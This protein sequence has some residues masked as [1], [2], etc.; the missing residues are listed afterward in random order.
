M[1]NEN[2]Q[3]QNSKSKYQMNAKAQ[4]PDAG[5]TFWISGFELLND[6]I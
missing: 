4:M 1:S 3:Y 5:K 6:Y 2:D